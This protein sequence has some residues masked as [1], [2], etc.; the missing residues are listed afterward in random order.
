M[1]TQR[2]PRLGLAQLNRTNDANV[3]TVGEWM[4]AINGENSGNMAIIDKEFGD[5]EEAIEL[6]IKKIQERIDSGNDTWFATSATAA[7]IAAKVIN[8]NSGQPDFVRRPGSIV[9]VHFTNGNTHATPT[10][11]IADTGVGNIRHNGENIGGADL[12]GANARVIFVWDGNGWEIINPTN[13][14]SSGLGFGTSTTAAAT[15]AK[16]GTIA[17]FVR[18]TGSRVTIMFSHANTALNPTLNVN[19]TGAAAI[20]IDGAALDNDTLARQLGA[21]LRNFV[22]NGTQWQL[23]N[24]F[25]LLTPD[26][27]GAAPA[28]HTHNTS[29]IDEGVLPIERGGTNGS[30]ADAARDNLGAEPVRALATQEE[31]EAGTSTEIR[32]WTPERVRQAATTAAGDTTLPLQATYGQTIT[33]NINLISVDWAIR[34]ASRHHILG[35]VF[36]ELDDMGCE[37]LREAQ[38]LAAVAASSTAMTAVI[39]SETAWTAIVNSSTAMT[40]VAA[41]GNA[42][43][44]ITYSA[45]A[46]RISTSPHNDATFVTAVINTARAATGIAQVAMAARAW[47]NT[48]NTHGDT[49]NVSNNAW[50][51]DT[52][53]PW[54]ITTARGIYA[55]RT[56][57]NAASAGVV[58]NINA[59]ISSRVDSVAQRTP[60]STSYSDHVVNRVIFGLLNLNNANMETT[61]AANAAANNAAGNVF[62]VTAP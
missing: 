24:P 55:F 28:S 41:S 3:M 37:G 5:L 18:R 2:T 31:A 22:F 59:V 16:V 20:Q 12:W 44:H 7:G 60:G 46:W 29:D 52:A 50:S 26:G 56:I 61:I 35:I 33:Q 8:L 25:V 1:A 17:N 15:A 45:Q 23:E 6:A 48:R 58:T 49:H 36:D 10:M 43:R 53:N 13:L 9:I 19:S 62:N 32:S 14:P 34:G 21:G 40:A 54:N 57:R 51:G 38:T 27:I 30:T 47:S 11:N 4:D 39:A 42:L